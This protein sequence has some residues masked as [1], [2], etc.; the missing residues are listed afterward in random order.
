MSS[1]YVYA[2]L[3]TGNLTPYYI[4]KGKRERAFIKHG[5]ITVPKDKSRIVFLE[6][7]LSEIG[8]FAIERRMIKW[9]GR[10]DN[11]TGILRNITDGGDGCSGRI[12]RHTAETKAKISAAQVGMLRGPHTEETKSKLKAARALRPPA[13]D[14]TRRRMS[15][16]L[17]GEKNPNFGKTAT[18]E[19][20]EAASALRRNIPRSPT[21]CAKHSATI[22]GIPK[23]KLT[24]PHCGLTGGTPQMKRYHFDNCKQKPM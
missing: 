6:C 20:L 4:G 1:Y 13:S 21:A 2:Y 24:C 12:Y 19:Q 3:R 17:R 18:A 7:N 10:K 14:E 9:Y 16:S 8:A 15:E 22:K 11:G 5:R 23:P